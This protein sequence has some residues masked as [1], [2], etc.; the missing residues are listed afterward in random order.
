[1]KRGGEEERLDEARGKLDSGAI[2]K[3]SDERDS[4]APQVRHTLH[5]VPT[6]TPPPHQLLIFAVTVP[7]S[8]QRRSEV[9]GRAHLPMPAARH[10]DSTCSISAMSPPSRMPH[11]RARFFG[12]SVAATLAPL[13]CISFLLSFPGETHQ[14][15]RHKETA[16]IHSR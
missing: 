12:M 6:D 2:G 14:Q 13:A 10:H 16:A 5:C 3:D 9:A 11:S 15:Q 1:M 4:F 8:L 7:S